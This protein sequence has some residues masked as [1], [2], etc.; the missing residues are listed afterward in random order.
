MVLIKSVLQE[1]KKRK[2]ELFRFFLRF[3]ISFIFGAILVY[4]LVFFIESSKFNLQSDFL[5]NLVN[6]FKGYLENF[7]LP[8][9]Q[10][11]VLGRIFFIFLNNLRVVIV[12]GILSFITFGIFSEIVAY[13]NG[14]VV[15]VIIFSLPFIFE[16]LN[17]L[18][19]FIFGIFPHGIFEIFAFLLSLTFAHS[20]S[21]TKSALNEIEIYLKSYI[22]VIPL[23]FIASIIEVTLTPLIMSLFILPQ[24]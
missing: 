5:K 8:Y 17:P 10:K 2:S 23:L 7:L 15:G 18:S 20:L 1:V 3:I 16:K 21:P 24:I 9:T 19:L 22:I 12:A 6:E 11:G 13:I 14:F 4:V